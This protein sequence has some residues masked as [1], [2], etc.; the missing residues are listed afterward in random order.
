MILLLSLIRKEINTKTTYGHV[1]VN[2]VVVVVKE[3]ENQEFLLMLHHRDE[4][5]FIFSGV[6][7]IN[8]INTFYDFMANSLKANL[9]KNF[10]NQIE[11]LSRNQL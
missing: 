7:K 8:L 2:V 11:A 4:S 3:E 5:S 9:I 10:K 1:K 6:L